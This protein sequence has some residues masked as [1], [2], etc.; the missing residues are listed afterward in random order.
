L[1]LA[2]VS[3]LWLSQ[4]P[5]AGE[6]KFHVV[7]EGDGQ[8]IFGW[9]TEGGIEVRFEN[10]ATPT[11]GWSKIFKPSGE[12]LSEVVVDEAEGSLIYL[13][14]GA[15][16]GRSIS[17]DDLDRMRGAITSPEARLV[18]TSLWSTVVGT[19]GDLSS[20]AMAALAANLVGYETG[21]AVGSPNRDR[22][23]CLG[24]C[25]PGC[26]GCTGCWTRACL[27][28]DLCVM[29]RGLADAECNRL[30]TL[31]ALSAWCCRG[32]YIKGLC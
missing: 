30:L 15:D 29:T 27:A 10:C 7:S 5:A 28:H 8:R 19:V 22:G 25:G 4:P 32:F 23:G 3:G 12:P 13:I 20:K 26:W 1:G 6:T 24:C 21:S 17:P 14:A 11:G 2:I 18:A 9:L 16:V 31:A